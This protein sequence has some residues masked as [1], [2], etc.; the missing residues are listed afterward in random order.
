MAA[1]EL[2]SADRLF[3][4]LDGRWFSVSGD[5]WRAEVYSVFY[6]GGWRW[7]QVGLHGAREHM[8]TLRTSQ[9]SEIRQLIRA[10]AEWLGSSEPR[11][12]TMSVA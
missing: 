1:D 3:Q 11:T 12:E 4:D 2:V 10:L 5:R 9:T 7:I 8:L 6:D